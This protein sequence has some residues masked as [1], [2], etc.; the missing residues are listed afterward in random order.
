MKIVMSSGHGKYIRGASGYLDEVDEARRVVDTIA[1]ILN[2]V[3]TYH[4]DVSHS[5]S[6]NLDRIVDFHNAQTR[7]LDVSVHFNAYVETTKPMGTECLYVTQ[8]ELAADVALAIADAGDLIN[9]GPKK[10]T[11]LAF[12]NGTEEPAILIEVCFV[13]SRADADNYRANFD[14]IC[15]AIANAISGNAEV[16]PPR[17]DV[18]EGALF[19]TQGPCSW[20]GGPRDAGVSPS[21]GLA[22]FYDLGDAPHLFLPTQPQGTTGLARRLN[23]KLFYVACRWNYDVTPKD[24]LSQPNL[25]ALVRAN[26]KEFLAWPADWGPHEDTGR[27]ADLSPGLTEALELETDDEVEVIYPA[28]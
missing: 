22:F 6:E 10:R 26:G 9:R 19:S 15:V 20:F 14:E 3:T 2:N 16:G 25:Q 8:N 28:P 7:D 4:D 27:V 11:D 17:P 24:M 12:L 21:E 13:D 5:Q 1:S 18:P 23:P